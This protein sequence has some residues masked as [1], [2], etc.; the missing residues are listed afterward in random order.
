MSDSP[1][2]IAP[3]I[4]QQAAEWMARLWSDEAGD[5]DR[6]ACDRWRAS[7][8]EHERAWR[9]LQSF[10]D[11]LRQ[12]PR[13]LA[14]QVLREPAAKAYLQR[15]DALRLLGV[16]IALGGTTYLARELGGWR[17]M[18]AEYATHTGEIREIALPDGT[19]VTLATATR[20]DLRFA[21]DER[22]LL[23]HEGE[24]LV[25]TAHDAARPSRPFRVQGR[26]G[27]VEALGTRFALRQDAEGS[28]LAVFEGR[29]ELR[30]GQTPG[31]GRLLD[32]GQ[33]TRYSSTEAEATRPTAETVVAWTRGV[34]LAENMRVAEFLA[35]LGRYRP[36][37]LRCAPAVGELRVSGVFSLRDTDRALHNLA[38]ALPVAIVYRT[39][40]WVTVLA[41][42]ATAG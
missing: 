18:F 9:E 30:T 27:V 35:E 29:V 19:R 5:A 12:L 26:D 7:H 21:P 22:R 17:G 3:A 15:R 1:S 24:I 39:R 37:M 11:K 28:R 20:L 40:Y 42:P 41:A 31:R 13:G 4:V 6:A 32:A 23:L 16:G 25:R 34:L 8:P 36:G 2:A 38:L 33:G 10:D 14:Q